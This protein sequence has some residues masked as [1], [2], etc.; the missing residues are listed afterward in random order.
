MPELEEIIGYHLE[1]SFRYRA[2][3]GPVDAQARSLGERAARHLG[4]AGTRAIDRGDMPAAASLFQRAA[5]LLDEGHQDRP[6]LLL[7]AGEALTDVGELAAAEATLTA[8]RNNAALLGNEA[9][10][11]WAELA[12]LQLRYT[13]DASSVRDAVVARVRDLLPV[14]E[15]SADHHGL[16]R[17]WRL[18]TYAHWT[19]A[20]FGIAAEAAEQTIRHATQAGDEVLAR[21][22]AVSMVASVLYG[23]TPV[24]EAIAYCEGVLSQAV[25]DRKVSAR[26]E[27]ALAHLEA[28]LGK[29]EAARVRYRRS[30]AL[31][32]E[33]GYRFFAALTSLD[34]ALVEMLAGDLAVAERELRTD[35]QTLEQM[36]ERNYISTTAGML[37]EVLYRQ[38]R[39]QESAELTGV[40]RELASPDD[41]TSQFLWRCVRAKLLARDGKNDQS[42]A[43]LAEALELISASDWVDWQGNGFMDLAE[44]RRLRGHTADAIEALGQASARFAAKGNVVSLRR[45]DELADK[46]RGTQTGAAL[47]SAQPAAPALTG[48]TGRYAE[49]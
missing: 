37:G 16:A 28:M 6:H 8:A 14:L 17:A 3:L 31:L 47:D 9:I 38:G 49:S 4:L 5:D 25:E 39:Y 36:G 43:I 24:G 2:E 30:R 44:V 21:R 19:A 48:L 32:E 40:C 18:L 27:V 20:R 26:A 46:L 7:E 34:S 1:Q 11:R 41:V 23:P 22:L 15:Q 35:Y 42:D 33:F 10:G 13:T 29:F 12:G 45:A